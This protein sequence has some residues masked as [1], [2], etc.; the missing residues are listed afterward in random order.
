MYILPEA[1]TKKK[2]LYSV[3]EVTDPEQRRPSYQNSKINPILVKSYW[4]MR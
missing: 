4:E 1:V 2:R 3:E